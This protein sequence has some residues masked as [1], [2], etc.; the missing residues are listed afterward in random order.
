LG[1]WDLQHITPSWAS[2]S[3]IWRSISALLSL[4]FTLTNLLLLK[5]P[6]CLSL[7]S[8]FNKIKNLLAP[9]PGPLNP[10]T[11]GSCKAKHEIK[12]NNKENYTIKKQMLRFE[13]EMSP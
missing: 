12:S 3:P 4:C 6:L 9:R 8:V 5:S 13:Y 11:V 7:N 10:V 2:C 1:S